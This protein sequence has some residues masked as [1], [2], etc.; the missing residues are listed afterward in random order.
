MQLASCCFC[1][2][3]STA[4]KLCSNFTR[5]RCPSNVC[6]YLPASSTWQS[7]IQAKMPPQS[8]YHRLLATDSG[9]LVISAFV[10]VSSQPYSFSVKH[11]ADGR[12][13]QVHG[14]VIGKT[15]AAIVMLQRDPT[16][17][18]RIQGLIPM[19]KPPSSRRPQRLH[20]S[21]RARAGDMSPLERAVNFLT[22]LI[23]QS[24]LHE[25]C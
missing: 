25:V 4:S 5:W 18:C 12:T 24:P 23:T 17:L 3:P 11:F 6:S 21:A 13:G 15:D 1:P 2:S 8:L 22:V 7:L 20:V 19:R 16:A 9:I 14:Y 10:P